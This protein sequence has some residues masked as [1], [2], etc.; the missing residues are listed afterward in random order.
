MV[1]RQRLVNWFFIILLIAIIAPAP[2]CAGPGSNPSGAAGSETADDPFPL[3]KFQYSRIVMGIQA[4]LTLYSQSEADAL[5]AAT[6]AFDRLDQLDAVMSDYRANSELSRLSDRA[7]SGPIPLSDDLWR[8]L[9]RAQEIS[10]LTGG[11]FDITVGPV[12]Q[13]WRAARR[14]GARPDPAIL[15]DALDLVGWQM[16][17]PS[18]DHPRTVELVKPGM[19][20][21]LGGI[22]KGFAADEALAALRANGVTRALVDLGGDL[23]ASGPPPG[24][25]GWTIAVQWHDR[26]R[27][28]IELLLANAALATSGD[29]EQFVE[30]G[31][32]VRYSH[33]VDPATGLGLTNRTAVTVIAPDGATADALA[34]AVSVLGAERGLAAIEQFDNVSAA[35][36]TFRPDGESIVRESPG[37]PWPAHRAPAEAE[38]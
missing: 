19:R 7:G 38:P 26:D 20:L 12:V 37:F 32:G 13:L 17:I 36:V 1:M 33:I 23:V 4:R 21:D 18:D 8:V 2:G 31:D 14:T 16:V 3:E 11:A 5:A 15:E 25:P 27:K 34:S 10:E 9:S 6:A 24:R 29:L 30:F 22:G 28:E 35:V